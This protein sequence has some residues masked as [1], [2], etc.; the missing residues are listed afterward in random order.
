MTQAHGNSHY[1][2]L[3]LPPDLD[4]K[5]RWDEG[6]LRAIGEWMADQLHLTDLS[7]EVRRFYEEK[8]PEVERLVG[9][10]TCLE[11]LSIRRGIPR[12]PTPSTAPPGSALPVLHR[13][14]VVPV[15]GLPAEPFLSYLRELEVGAKTLL[16]WEDTPLN[17][18][19][20][21][22]VG[23]ILREATRDREIFSAKLLREVS[24]GPCVNTAQTLP[25]R[26]PKP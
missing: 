17:E 9:Q 12:A 18:R 3:E 11:E 6:D 20:R 23:G 8:I 24:Q 4:T 19:E 26:E 5:E 10:G 25:T 22:I 16:S 7:E 15:K 14:L 13:A 2:A 1:R 21:A